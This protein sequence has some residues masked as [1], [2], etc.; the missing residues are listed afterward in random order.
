MKIIALILATI[1]LAFAGCSSVEKTV[2]KI[3]GFNFETWSHSDRYGVFTDTVTIAG[4]KWTLNLDGSATLEVGQYDG[5]VAWA[6][7]VGPHDTFSK[8]V[9]NF[10]PDS[11]QAK[12]LAH[13]LNNPAAHTP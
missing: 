13:F 3:P 6:G 11:P 2:R 4:A 5:Q 1:A 9:V 10:P 8:L 7:T 12:T